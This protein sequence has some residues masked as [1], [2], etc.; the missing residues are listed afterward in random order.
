MAIIHS[1]EVNVTFSKGNDIR[2]SAKVAAHTS[3]A[4]CILNTSFVARKICWQ[5][6]PRSLD[7]VCIGAAGSG[8]FVSVSDSLMQGASV[9]YC[10][11]TGQWTEQALSVCVNC[12]YMYMVCTIDTYQ[13]ANST[14][15]DFVYATGGPAAVL[16]LPDDNGICEKERR[17]A[18]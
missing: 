1:F 7:A 14:S 5:G 9:W 6:E 4:D 17:Y 10:Q 12:L 16:S 2:L 11:Y 13:K 18:V 8:K 3:T 15:D